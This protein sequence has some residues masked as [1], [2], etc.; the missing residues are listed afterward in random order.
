MPGHLARLLGVGSWGEGVAL[1]PPLPLALS[2]RS[3]FFFF[4]V[5]PFLFCLR[6]DRAIRDATTD[7]GTRLLA[8]VA[9][10][11]A[12]VI[13]LRPTG[14]TRRFPFGKFPECERRPLFRARPA[15]CPAP[16][17][18][19]RARVYADV[20]VQKPKEYWDYENLQVTWG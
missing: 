4:Y 20:N 16:P 8:A 15:V 6:P 18:M 2:P 13:L 3:S 10:F 12:L 17:A 11:A 9:F 19:S 1:R 5:V 7:L 14:T